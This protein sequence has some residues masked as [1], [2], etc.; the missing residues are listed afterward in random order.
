MRMII[1][2]GKLLCLVFWVMLV[3]SFFE[4]FSDDVSRGLSVSA[5]AILFVHLVEVAI[6]SKV[7]NKVSVEPKFDKMQ[8]LLFGLFHLLVLN[9]MKGERWRSDGI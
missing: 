5:V 1:L 6:F 8:V 2:I 9:K 4:V 7:I 3:V